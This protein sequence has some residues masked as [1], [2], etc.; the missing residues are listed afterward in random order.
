VA[1]VGGALRELRPGRWR[2]TAPHPAAVDEPVLRNGGR[3]LDRTLE[4]R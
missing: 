3:A 2:W 4:R 1:A